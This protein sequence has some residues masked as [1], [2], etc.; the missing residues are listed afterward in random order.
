MR[1][2]LLIVLAVVFV[3]ALVVFANWAFLV[4]EMDQVFLT[5]FGKPLPGGTISEPG[6]KFRPIPFIDQVRRFDRRWLEWDGDVNQ[7]PTKDKKYIVVDT[8]AR[9]R[10]SDPLTFYEK[11]TDERGAQTRLDDIIDGATRDTIASYN[12]IEMVRSS[13]RPFEVSEE[14]KGLLS[15][16]SAETVSAGR[17]QIERE[18]LAVAAEKVKEFGIELVD[19]RFKR[20]DYEKSV[21]QRVYE[22][23][24][25]ERKRIAEQYRSEGQGRSAEILGRKERDLKQIQSEAYR[26]AEEIRGRA[27]AEATAIYAAAYSRDPEFYTFVKTLETWD[28][29]IDEGTQIILTTDSDLLRYLEKIR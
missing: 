17:A 8:F 3:V 19:V 18:I 22:R 29:T 23:M 13:N 26:K 25:T 4:T 11:L 1:A 21:S 15:E 27:D 7:I 20:I 10:I 28:K 9:W 14:L 12:L 6:L 24:I 2:P 16:S 5:R